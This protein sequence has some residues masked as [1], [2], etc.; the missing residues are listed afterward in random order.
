MPITLG[1]LELDP[2][3]TSVREHLEEVGGRDERRFD[4][5]G[6]I[7]GESTVD[8]IE[9]RL[10]AILDV[11]SQDDYSAAFSLRPGRRFWVRREGFARTIA[12]D[13]LVG[14]FTLT[15]AARDPFE[16]AV[17]P[18]VATW[19]IS[20][21]GATT[22]LSTA[23]NLFSKPAVSLVAVGDLVNPSFSDGER[24]IAY[25]GTVGD[26]QTLVFDAP[27]GKVLLDGEDVTP[28]CSGLFPRIEPEGTTL[29]YEDD[30]AGSHT[31]DVT[32][33]YRDRWW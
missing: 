2:E 13:S 18:T 30:A 19:A 22:S 14:S 1:T 3:H 4:V 21:S 32:V 20:A 25:T 11:A 10:D 26:A 6:L 23:G 31:A 24:T 15:L 16:V 8:A 27:E 17:D 9:A 29:T 28:Y 33:T 5:T 7:T 12:R